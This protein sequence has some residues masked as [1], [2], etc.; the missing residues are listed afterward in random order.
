MVAITE[1]DLVASGIPVNA[2]KGWYL[3]LNAN[4]EK[5]VNAPFTVGGVTYFATNK[6]TPTASG[7]CATSL[8]EAR[9]YAVDFLT[10]T[11][12]LDR[13]GNG[14]KDPLDLSV[15]LSGGGLPPSPVGGLVQLDNGMLVNFVIG[16]GGGVGQSSALAPE[17]PVLDIKRTLRKLYW[18]TDTDK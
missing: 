3:A 1:A 10:G 6:P 8:G 15:K 14:V 5:V 13:N 16:G 4:G 12:G 2:A 9:A 7:S 17:Q 18:N 11:A